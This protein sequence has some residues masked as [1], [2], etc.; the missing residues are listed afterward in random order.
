MLSESL[1]GIM[2][3]D[4]MQKIII[5]FLLSL[6]LILTML[7]V[8]DITLDDKLK[9]V[10]LAQAVEINYIPLGADHTD[11]RI[12]LKSGRRGCCVPVGIV[13]AVS[14]DIVTV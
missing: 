4:A 8:N 12:V 11:F 6:N 10:D 5:T 3:E 9:I 2:K 7:K 1:R 13:P 14:I